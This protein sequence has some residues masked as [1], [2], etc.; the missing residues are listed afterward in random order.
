MIEFYIKKEKRKGTMK[1]EKKEEKKLRADEVMMRI[2][3]RQ[4]KDS[5]VEGQIICR[6]D[7]MIP[8]EGYKGMVVGVRK[9]RDKVEIVDDVKKQ[10]GGVY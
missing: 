2:G 4:R 7:I 5:D 6:R 9:R 3:S 8:K 1:E 10:V